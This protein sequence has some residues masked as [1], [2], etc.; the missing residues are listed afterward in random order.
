MRAT[1]RAWAVVGLASFLTAVP[2]SADIVPVAPGDFTGFRSKAAGTL[3]GSGNWTAAGSGLAVSWVITE[4]AGVYTY[5]YDFTNGGTQGGFS[6]LLLETSLNFLQS[7][8]QAGSGAVD[9][10]PRTF[11]PSDP[12]NGNPNLP[13]D[14]Y[15]M[16]YD[17]AGANSGSITLITR[18]VPVWGDFYAKDGDAGGLG[19]NAIWTT[20]FGL[21]PTVTTSNFSG[22]IPTPDTNV[23]AVVPLPPA[24]WAGLAMLGG[25]ATFN[26]LRRR[27]VES[28]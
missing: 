2:A 10:G 21:D 24:A 6:H 11:S 7:D 20:S 28:E 27:F 25:A 8:L 26:R 23:V 16:K 5:V 1:R 18:R 15:G 3:N 9:E 13:A 12:G 22:W 17:T 19:A 4:A 14:L